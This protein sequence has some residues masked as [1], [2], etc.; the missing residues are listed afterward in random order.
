MESWSWLCFFLSDGSRRV[1]T[2]ICSVSSR[3]HNANSYLLFTTRLCENSR[4]EAQKCYL[5][6]VPAKSW[7][8]P[9]TARIVFSPHAVPMPVKEK[10][11]D[12]RQRS[13]LR[14]NTW[15]WELMLGIRKTCKGNTPKSQPLQLAIRI[16]VL[17]YTSY[18]M[19]NGGNF[20]HFR[21]PRNANIL[22]VTNWE[23]PPLCCICIGSCSTQ[24]WPPKSNGELIRINIQQG[25]HSAAARGL[26][27]LSNQALTCKS[28][29]KPFPSQTSPL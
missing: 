14:P 1:I 19:W 21:Y 5:T 29:T 13:W 17:Y 3:M 25:E 26:C 24:G 12:E 7:H 28:F 22:S 23:P 6:L 2:S 10:L 18:A 15:S 11:L 16:T 20:P 8:F 4:S 27:S 9:I